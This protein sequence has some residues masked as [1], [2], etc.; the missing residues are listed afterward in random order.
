MRWSITETLVSPTTKTA[1]ALARNTPGL[2]IIFWYKGN[3]FLRPDNILY[4]YQ[5]HLTVDGKECDFDIIH[6]LPFFPCVW[7]TLRK[8]CRCPGNENI[9]LRTCDHQKNCAFDIC[10]YG[11]K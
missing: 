7:Q 6:T 3:Y 2:M 5:E 1:F 10:P 9:S 8:G 11:I 4:T